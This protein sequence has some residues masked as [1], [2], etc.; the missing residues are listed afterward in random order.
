MSRLKVRIRDW[1]SKGKWCLVSTTGYFLALATG[2][3]MLAGTCPAGR[4][5]AHPISAGKVAQ[6]SLGSPGYIPLYS[7]INEEC[8]TRP[9]GHPHN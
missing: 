8:I 2:V 4:F 6:R 1:A 3:I 9:V 7:L 5:Q